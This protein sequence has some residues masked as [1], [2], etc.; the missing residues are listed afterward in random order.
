MHGVLHPDWVPDE[1]GRYRGQMT[2]L[3][4]PNGVFGAT[5]LSARR[6]FS[7]LH[8]VPLDGADQW[9][10]LADPAGKGPAAAA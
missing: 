4:K 9:D 8:R 7:A 6:P 5:S 10:T 2:V 1:K 3:V